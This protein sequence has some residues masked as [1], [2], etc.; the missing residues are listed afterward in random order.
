MDTEDE[1][2]VS[3]ALSECSD[4]AFAKGRSVVKMCYV[5]D[6]IVAFVTLILSVC[7][8][9]VSFVVLRFSINFTDGV[10]V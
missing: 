9:I 10:C 8:M 3:A 7:L 5:M 4:I 1:R 6:M 2:A